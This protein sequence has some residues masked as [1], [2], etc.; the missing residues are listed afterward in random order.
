MPSCKR[1]TP[2]G[3]SSL[4]NGL[5]ARSSNGGSNVGDAVGGLLKSNSIGMPFSGGSKSIDLEADLD[6]CIGADISGTEGLLGIVVDAVNS[7]LSSPL[8][9]NVGSNVVRTPPPT[10]LFLI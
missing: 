9:I 8:G 10:S 3:S 7:L 4:T 1:A 6:V 5:L 2:S